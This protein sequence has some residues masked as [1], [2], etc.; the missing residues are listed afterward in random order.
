MNDQ[1]TE[2]QQRVTRNEDDIEALQTCM[3]NQEKELTYLKQK[4]E[5]LEDFS[6]RLNVRILNVPERIEGQDMIGFV[7]KLLIH[8]FG[9]EHFPMA[10]QIKNAHRFP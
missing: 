10:P 3:G 4:V 5:G 8:L 2:V 1:V 6:R 9:Q 7:Q